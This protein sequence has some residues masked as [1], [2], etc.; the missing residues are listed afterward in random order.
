MENVNLY[1][2]RSFVSD[3]AFAFLFQINIPFIQ[4]DE[5]E[6]L[7]ISALAKSTSLPAYNIEEKTIDFRDRKIK[8]GG[9]ASF[10]DW[11]VTFLSDD[12]C[13]LRHK[14]LLWQSLIY[15]PRRDIIFSPASY[16][17]NGVKVILL[18]KEGKPSTGYEFVGLFPKRVDQVSI[19]HG[20]R[21]IVEFA[22]TFSYDYY[23]INTTFD[24]SSFNTLDKI[25]GSASDI[26]TSNY[27]IKK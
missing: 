6:G 18:S 1:T 8:L 19:G 11:S 26:S 27:T 4:A 13:K 22:V 15:D 5:K 16:K 20:S 25:T 17:K 23:I 7:I 12:Q 10:D 24:V 3:F 14:F 21:N 2:F 9:S